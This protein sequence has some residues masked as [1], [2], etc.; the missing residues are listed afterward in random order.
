MPADLVLFSQKC[1]LIHWKSK[2]KATWPM[3]LHQTCQLRTWNFISQDCYI[4]N[5]TYMPCRELLCYR[6]CS[7]NI[8]A[9]WPS[10]TVTNTA[11]FIHVYGLSAAA[12]WM[13]ARLWPLNQHACWPFVTQYCMSAG[14]V[15]LYL[16]S[17][18]QPC[19]LAWCFIIGHAFWFGTSLSAMPV[20]VVPHFRPCLL[21]WCL[22]VGHVFWCGASLKAMPV[23]VVPHYRPCLLVRFALQPAFL[24]VECRGNRDGYKSGATLTEMP[25]HQTCL[26][27][28]W[29]SNIC[30]LVQ[31]NYIVYQTCMLGSFI[32]IHVF[33]KCFSLRQE[34]WYVTN[35]PDIPTGKV[36]LPRVCKTYQLPAWTPHWID[37]I[38]RVMSV[39]QESVKLAFC[40]QIPKVC[41]SQVKSSYIFVIN[42]HLGRHFDCI[43]I[44]FFIFL[45]EAKCLQ[46]DSNFIAN[47]LRKTW[48]WDIFPYHTIIFTYNWPPS[49][50]PS[51][52]YR[53]AQW[54]Q[55]GITR[56]FQGQYMHYISS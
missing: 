46:L 5:T 39:T 53:N 32:Q 13:L 19:L 52:I 24:L 15:L 56:I 1:L 55:S 26:L 10:A 34:I 6:S 21:V 48:V 31:C 7:C 20:D 17:H 22:T 3:P 38:L 44:L 12:R 29:H 18:Y 27:I 41:K 40:M 37:H 33:V 28:L 14:G 42:C 47:S 8:Y 11:V 54:C 23:G 25:L 51:W 35:P 50:T 43:L 49:W 30:L 45:L 4:V 2:R 36:P 16:L 9:C